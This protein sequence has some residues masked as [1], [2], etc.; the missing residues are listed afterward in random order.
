MKENLIDYFKKEK[1]V[2]ILA[3]SNPAANIRDMDRLLKS[4]FDKTGNDFIS[5]VCIDK[6][7]DELIGCNDNYHTHNRNYK[8]IKDKKKQKRVRNMKKHSKKRNIK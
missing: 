1:H 5:D 8:K 4:Y 6:I 2:K 7:P 3:A